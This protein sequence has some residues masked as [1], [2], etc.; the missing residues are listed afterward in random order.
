MSSVA[1]ARCSPGECLRRVYHFL[2]PSLV[3]Y[4]RAEVRGCRTALDLGCGKDSPLR[5]CP[6]IRS[7]GVDLFEGY[8]EESRRR[9]IHDRYLKADV[10]SVA[11]PPASF[12]VVLAIDLI[13]HLTEEEGYQLIRRMEEWAGRKVILFTPNGYVPQEA[14]DDNFLQRHRSGWTPAELRALG[15]RVCG[16]GGIKGLCNGHGGIKY[17]PL[18][19][20][21]LLSDLTQIITYRR[22]EYAFALLA[23]KE[24]RGSE[25]VEGHRASC[26]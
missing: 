1:R 10:R 16:V 8:L 26:R 20:W 23:V 21:K 17:R 6:G 11:F 14:Y 13:E 18:R 24:V 19:L 15:F 12:D 22:P 7:V 5:H 25:E 9:G 4:V 2:F 3:E